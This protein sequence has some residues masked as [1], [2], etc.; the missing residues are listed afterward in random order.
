M[1]TSRMIS[2]ILIYVTMP[3]CVPM[4]EIIKSIR[5]SLTKDDKS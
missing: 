5:R 2:I 3:K 1:N 4:P